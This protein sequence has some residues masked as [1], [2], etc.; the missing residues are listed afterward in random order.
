MK[1][2]NKTIIELC[3]LAVLAVLYL[4]NV[5]H[6]LWTLPAPSDP[7]QYFRS[8]V[9][10]TTY[11][12]WPWL[13]RIALAVNLRIFSVIFSGAA[14]AGAYYIAF[15]NV[16]ILAV[17]MF[18]SYRKAG[19]FA[20]L[21]AGI[22]F[23]VS[24]FT[25]GWATYLYPDQTVAL[26]GLL[27]F[28]FF[29][30]ERSDT[31]YVRP[32]FLAGFFSGL[33]ILTKVTA[34][35]IPLFF[36]GYLFFYKDRQK[37]K[38][39][40][41][42]MAAG[43]AAIVLLF[44][45]L[46]NIQSFVDVVVSFFKTSLAENIG[47]NNLAD[48]PAN[49]YHETILSLMYFPLIA[50]LV[51]I[52][53]YRHR[54]SRNLFILAGLI[55]AFVALL[56]SVGP[57]IPSYVYAADIFVIIGLA[58][59]AADMVTNSSPKRE[60]DTMRF[61]LALALLFLVAAGFGLAVRYAPVAQFGYGYN[62]LAPLDVYSSGLGYPSWIRNLYACGPLVLLGLLAAFEFFRSKKAAIALMAFAAFWGAFFNGGL[63]F[64]KAAADRQEA[65]L[66]Y[67]LAPALSEVPAEKFSFFINDLKQYSGAESRL[68]MVYSI[69]FDTKYQRKFTD[70]FAAQAENEKIVKASIV[71]IA[72]EED[73]PLRFAGEQL[74]TDSPSIALNYFPGAQVVKK[75]PAPILKK[76]LV[77]MSIPRQDTGAKATFDQAVKGAKI[78]HQE[79]FSRLGGVKTIE[80]PN[81]LEALLSPLKYLGNNGSFSFAQ[82]AADGGNALNLRPAVAGSGQAS[83]IALGYTLQ[84]S[85][86][87]SAAEVYMIMK[88]TVRLEGASST[89]SLFIQDNTGVWDKVTVPVKNT[90]GWQDVF[91]TKRI[92]SGATAIV[93]GITFA[94]TSGLDALS[95]SD[96]ELYS[97]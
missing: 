55:I 86:A 77:V 90:S 32:M 63:A 70:R 79:N 27:S 44:I 31:K 9:W 62:Y 24:Y 37:I 95:V 85:A 64:K 40:V 34:L 87:D 84:R 1:I 43:C 22:L 12:Y 76:D 36:I 92:R 82:I 51:A 81:A 75:I 10:G 15:I 78:I 93:A 74:L 59:Y 30:S 67:A 41:F 94:S 56:R 28:I 3:A 57:A 16:A 65:G 53:A 42:G 46:Y 17:A 47:I 89:S 38:R 83:D 4:Y 72:R 88:A 71:G 97:K 49:Y 33:A 39:F 61:G 54:L 18:W 68:L 96:L 20:A 19:F 58:L 66:Y 7:L 13:D 91:I 60:S 73:L 80:N 5:A 23:N 45:A 11:G 69:F 29:F 21:F 50:L 35:I 25:L 26:Y 14:M 52:G 48:R 2:N 6:S 8:A